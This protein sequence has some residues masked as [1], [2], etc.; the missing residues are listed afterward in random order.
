MAPVDGGEGDEKRA[1]AN[2]LDGRAAFRME[3][4]LHGDH[5]LDPTKVR[6]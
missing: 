6:R 2:V 5:I 3:V 4:S 1:A